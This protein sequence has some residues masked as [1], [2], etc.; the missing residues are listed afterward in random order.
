MHGYYVSILTHSRPEKAQGDHISALFSILANIA[1]S[2][3]KFQYK[4]S[5]NSLTF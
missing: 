3:V 2:L 4:N 1:V 5:D